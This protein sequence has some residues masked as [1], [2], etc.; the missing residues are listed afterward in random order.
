MAT[1]QFSYVNGT[2]IDANENN[3]NENELYSNIDPSNV[4]PAN[5]VG[6]GRFLLETG[7]PGVSLDSPVI[8]GTPTIANY[9]NAQHNHTSAAQGGTLSTAAIASGTFADARIAQSNVTQHQAAL[10]IAETQI[11]DGSILARVGS[12]ETITQKWI[13]NPSGTPDFAID[14]QTN[15]ITNS[16]VRIEGGTRGLFLDINTASIAQLINY[17]GDGTAIDINSNGSHVGDQYGLDVGNVGNTGA[18]DAIGIKLSPVTDFAFEVNE[19][20]T[21]PTGGGGAATG[22]IKIKVNGVTRYIPYY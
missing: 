17:S 18:G 10:S 21:D 11:P 6:S 5:K 20:N 4:Q 8:T 22:R 12:A 2:T 3:A 1:R 7:A 14:I 19:D 9:T 13:F 15:G 16:G